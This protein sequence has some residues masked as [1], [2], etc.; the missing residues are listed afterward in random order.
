MKTKEKKI[1]EDFGDYE[2]VAGIDE[3]GRGCGA[4]PVVTASVIMPKGF[5]SPLIR[6]S[7]KLSEKQRLE[8]YQLILDNAIAISCQS[9]FVSDIDELGINP[10]TFNTMVKNINEISEILSKS[11]SISETV[12]DQEKQLREYKDPNR[13]PL[14]IGAVLV[15]GTE[16]IKDSDIKVILV[17]KGDDTYT[18][19]AAAA[20]V[21]KVRRDKYMAQLH[22]LHPEYN[23]NKNKG[24]LTPEHIDAL[25]KYG[26]NKYHRKQYVKN[27][28][29]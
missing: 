1:L 12:W 21:A 25:K 23:W 20:I 13:E 8:A 15:D 28:I 2:F 19:I 6:D 29:N 27:F 26:P 22:E 17:P 18:C 14:K 3:V 24:Y 10:T 9:G 7:K 16:W 4:G 11:Y 5:K